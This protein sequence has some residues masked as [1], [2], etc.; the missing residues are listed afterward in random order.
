[1]TDH[2]TPWGTFLA[3]E[4]SS[5]EPDAD[6]VWVDFTDRVLDI[7]RDLETWLGRDSELD[8]PKPGGMSVQLRNRDDALTPGN[9]TSPYFP[10]WKQA[11]RFR[12]REIIG[13]FGFDLADGYLEIPEV[14]VR[15]QDPADS[16]SD[17]TLSVTAVDILGRLQNARRFVSTLAEHIKYEGGTALKAYWPMHDQTLPFLNI[18]GDELLPTASEQYV[19]AW[20]DPT[21]STGTAKVTP[22][23]VD[24]PPGDDVRAPQYELELQ[25]VGGF[26]RPGRSM[27]VRADIPSGTLPILA[28]EYATVVLWV[29]SPWTAID[30]EAVPLSIRWQTTGEGVLELVK[31]DGAV[32]GWLLDSSGSS[33]MVASFTSAVYPSTNRWTI[34]AVRWRASPM[35]IELW[36]DGERAVGVPAGAV[37][38]A[39]S[40]ITKIY[41]PQGRFDGN[42]AHVQVYIGD[43]DA[44][45]W[46]DFVAQRRVGL[47]GFDRQTTG[48][49]VNTIL[50][51]AGFPA[52]RRDVDAGS[53]VMS[54]VSLAGKRPLELLE[55]ATETEQG[56]LFAE[57]GRVVF[58]DRIHVH[59]V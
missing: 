3:F 9:P 50:N 10:W 34:L 44:F 16:E 58:H 17:V 14:Q 27:L 48:E 45:T 5:A 51:F 59:D 47:L 25:T 31:Q 22:A 54:R 57:A 33:G 53:A 42:I 19:L 56:R 40:E 7:G 30:S 23:A 43:E 8:E 29:R 38:G 13:Y 15:T 49:R 26:L 35:E 36:V 32:S 2:M 18:V 46:D 20:G 28:A 41:M 24:T 6:P 39:S 52:G 1:M 37:G 4:V 12:V 55:E 21:A 11:R